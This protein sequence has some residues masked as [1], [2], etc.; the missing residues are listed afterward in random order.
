[1]IVNN[2]DPL[3]VEAYITCEK[4]PGGDWFNLVILKEGAG[5]EDFTS[6]N[7]VHSTT[8]KEVAPFY[9]S[10]VR[11]HRGVMDMDWGGGGSLT[12]SRTLSLQYRDGA[13]VSREVKSWN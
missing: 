9:Y 11:I 10:H 6:N 5:V 1:M 12:F 13:V 8:V 3:V 2:F 7:L 4:E